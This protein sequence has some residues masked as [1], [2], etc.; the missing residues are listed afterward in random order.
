MVVVCVDGWGGEGNCS[1]PGTNN[2]HFCRLSL[3]DVHILLVVYI[4]LHT[5]ASLCRIRNC[6]L[7]RASLS[8]PMK[9]ILETEFSHVFGR[10]NLISTVRYISC[11]VYINLSACVCLIKELFSDKFFIKSC[12][13]C[14]LALKKIKYNFVHYICYLQ[15]LYDR[16]KV[17]FQTAELALPDH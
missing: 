15:T 14:I 12:Y 2:N 9:K 3:F 17:I 16:K 1:V 7:V 5:L 11:R 4:N 10:Y 6:C 8:W 13:L